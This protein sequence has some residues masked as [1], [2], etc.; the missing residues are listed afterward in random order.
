MDGYTVAILLIGALVMILLLPDIQAELE[1]R[2][3]IKHFND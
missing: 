2:D 1:K 3:Y